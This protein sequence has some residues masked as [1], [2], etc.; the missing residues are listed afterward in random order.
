MRH[1]PVLL[2]YITK[3][4]IRRVK[5]NIFGTSIWWF[6]YT[7]Y[8]LLTILIFFFNFKITHAIGVLYKNIS[9]ISNIYI[10]SLI[11]FYICIIHSKRTLVIV[12]NHQWLWKYYFHYDTSTWSVEL[13][14]VLF[15]FKRLLSFLIPVWRFIFRLIKIIW[16]KSAVKINT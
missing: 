14:H 16:L 9:K 3:I 2:I 6:F 13:L 4:F 15:I 5:K 8:I 7:K 10:H 12:S 1:P 11:F